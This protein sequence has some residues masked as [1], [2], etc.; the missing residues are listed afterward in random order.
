MIRTDR[1]LSRCP[2]AGSP[3]FHGVRSPEATGWRSFPAPHWIWDIFSGAELTLVANFVDAFVVCS[4]RSPPRQHRHDRF[5]KGPSRTHSFCRRG[6]IRLARKRMFLQRAPESLCA[7]IDNSL[8]SRWYSRC[9]LQRFTPNESLWLPEEATIS[10][11]RPPAVGCRHPSAS[12]S[13]SLAICTL[14]RWRA[15]HGSRWWMSE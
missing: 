1:L 2:E 4:N 13:T 14:S 10:R 8:S 12:T 6:L 5:Q 11:V 9:W 15:G 3:F 7:F